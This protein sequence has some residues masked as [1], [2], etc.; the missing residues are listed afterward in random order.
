MQPWAEILTRAIVPTVIVLIL[1]L[2]IAGLEYRVRKIVE[3][4]IDALKL[5]DK[6]KS[7]DEAASRAT[8]EL[9]DR[10]DRK[11]ESADFAMREE[12]QRMIVRMENVEALTKRNSERL[13]EQ[14]T[15][16]GVFWR[17]IEES[18][19]DLLLSRRKPPG[20]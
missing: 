12:L 3:G 13:V 11:M 19:A 9:G 10:I 14:E 6:A 16:T 15:K 4:R 1:G 2:I 17:A 5:D 7:A 18:T 20:E 8:K